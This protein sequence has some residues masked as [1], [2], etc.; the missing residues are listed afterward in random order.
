MPTTPLI[1][2][3]DDEAGVASLLAELLADEGYRTVTARDG[4]EA[5]DAVRAQ[6]PDLVITDWMMPN[7]NGAGLC[8]AL[9]ADLWNR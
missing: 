7:L 9:G 2:V 6:P 1:L 5:L 3:V 4:T 8:A